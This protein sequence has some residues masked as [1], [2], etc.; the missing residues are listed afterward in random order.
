MTAT[1]VLEQGTRKTRRH[2]TLSGLT[3]V[4]RLTAMEE[5]RREVLES[6]RCAMRQ[7]PIEPARSAACHFLL[8]HLSQ[9]RF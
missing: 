7:R 1:P 9:G 4:S 5:E 8:Q 3:L 6:V 2:R